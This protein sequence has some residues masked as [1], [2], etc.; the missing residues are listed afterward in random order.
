MGFG[1]STDIMVCTVPLV[2]NGDNGGESYF[3]SPRAQW[4]LK[5]TELTLV[6][7][8][9]G[10][11]LASKIVMQTAHCDAIFQVISLRWAMIFDETREA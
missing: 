10:L 1:V 4:G 11:I 9:C 8:F 3:F 6:V 5:E 2:D 7:S